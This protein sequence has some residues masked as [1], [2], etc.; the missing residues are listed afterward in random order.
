MAARKGLYANIKA[1]RDRIAHGSGEKMRKP[2]AKGAPKADAF[3]KAAKTARKKPSKK[4]AAARKRP[5]RKAA[6]TK[7]A[8]PRKTAAKKTPARKSTGKRKAAPAR[9]RPAKS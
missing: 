5:A 4:A 7:K 3:R 8:A 9:R 1:K 2:G 6:A